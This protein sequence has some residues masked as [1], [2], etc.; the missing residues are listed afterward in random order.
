MPTLLLSLAT[1]FWGVSFIL[2]KIALQEISPLSFIFFRFLIAA[3]CLLPGLGYQKEKLKR[4][5]MMRGAQ[6][7]VLLGG[8]IFLQTIG[9]QTITASVSAFLTGFAVVFVLAIR[10]VVQKKAPCFL[11]LATALTCV[12]GLGLVTRSHGLTWEPGV[13]YTLSC[14]FF[15]ALYIYALAAYAGNSQILILTLSQMVAL[16]LLA[17]LAAVS[18]ESKVQIPTQAATWAAI[19]FCAVFCSAVCSGIQAYAQQYLSAFKASMITTLEP[20]FATI[21]SCL[22]LGEV[23]P[24]SFYI[25][26]SMIL[27]A[28]GL[29][30][31]RLKG[32]EA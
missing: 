19:L 10:F 5:D 11:D 14:A 32:F 16:T 13:F 7:G 25:G 6:L 4:K 1:V 3:V 24:F 9:L 20:V 15:I 28:I 30:N 27:G 23:L 12:A 22:L 2:T 26:A 29:I 17:G 31:W 18:L 8:I 21:F